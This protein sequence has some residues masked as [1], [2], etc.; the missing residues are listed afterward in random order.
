MEVALTAVDLYLVSLGLMTSEHYDGM[1]D[2]EYVYY[3][4]SADPTRRVTVQHYQGTVLRE[5]LE[6]SFRYGGVDI[7]DFDRWLKDVDA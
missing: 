7:D 1:D 4:D 6:L 5:D 3:S 2:S